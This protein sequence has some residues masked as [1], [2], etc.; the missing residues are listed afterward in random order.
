M[1]ITPCIGAGPD[2]Q[3]FLTYVNARLAEVLPAD[4]LNPP[5]K[6]RPWTPT[7]SK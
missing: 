6:A 7:Q 5:W 1:N 4:V 3:Q 2:R